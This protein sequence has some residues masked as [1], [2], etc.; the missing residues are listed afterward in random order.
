MTCDAPPPADLRAWRKSERARLLEVRRAMAVSEYRAATEAIAR[1]LREYLPPGSLDLVGCYWPI[2]R[3]FN[4]VPYMRE[5]VRAGGGVALP[6][7]KGRGQPLE[8]RRWTETAAM[9]KGVWNIPHPAD[10]PPVVPTALLISLVGFDDS[11]FRLGY[12]AAYY[13]ITLAALPPGTLAIG[14]GFEFSRL[15]SIYPQPHDRPMH[16]IVTE[17]GVRERA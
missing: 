2:R 17:A 10:G 1:R 12:G 11:G 16:A 14:I 6:L 3:E 4:L 8:F 13:D 7:V 5:T 9:E 15:S